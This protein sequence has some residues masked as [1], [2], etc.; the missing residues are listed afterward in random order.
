MGWCALKTELKQKNNSK[1]Q[2][3]GTWAAIIPIIAREY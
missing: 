1:G 2:K 3:K